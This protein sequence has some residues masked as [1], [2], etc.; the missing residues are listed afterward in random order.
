M[1]HESD[2]WNYFRENALYLNGEEEIEGFDTDYPN[3]PIILVSGIKNENELKADDLH[4]GDVEALY[5]RRRHKVMVQREVNDNV[6]KKINKIRGIEAYLNNKEFKKIEVP[7]KSLIIVGDNWYI[8]YH[9]KKIIDS[10]LLSSDKLSRREFLK[11]K[12]ILEQGDS[13]SYED[14]TTKITNQRP[15]KLLKRKISLK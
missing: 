1:E 5:A 4:F 11:T 15:Y 6:L 8:V 3:Y 14:L 2:D 13:T 9:D 12:E 10:L 7:P